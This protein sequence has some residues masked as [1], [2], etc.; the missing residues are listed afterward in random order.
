M[1]QDMTY[2]RYL[3]LDQLL[4]AQQPLS[5]RHDELLFIV[6]HQTKELWLK[7]IIHEVMLAMRLVAAHDLEPAY[8]ALAR[9]SRIQTVMTLSWDVLATMTPADYLSFR[10]ELGSSSGFQSHQF[11]TLEY[12]LGLKDNSFLKFQQEGSS[13][14]A[15]LEAALAAPSLYD[16]AIAQ[17]AKAGLAV[18]E[19]VLARDFSQTYAPSP[20]VEAAWLEVYRDTK[21]Y[22]ELYQLA[23]KLVDLDDALVTWRHKHVLTVERIIGGR[24]GTGGTDGVGYLTSTLRRRAFPELWSLRTKL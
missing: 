20:E 15:Q 18:P 9:V 19:A 13:A 24:P 8:K 17:L 2:A 12:L 23:E 5:D 7:E 1:A 16:L 22:W 14:L 21:R 11:R 4:A 10:G 3:A 6:I